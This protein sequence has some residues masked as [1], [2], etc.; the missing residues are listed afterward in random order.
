MKY[1]NRLIQQ[2]KSNY[3]LD[4]LHF[5]QGHKHIIDP[6]DPRRTVSI[7]IIVASFKRISKKVY[8]N[9][10]D[11]VVGPRLTHAELEWVLK[12]FANPT[13][14]PP[15]NWKKSPQFGSMGAKTI[16]FEPTNTE[17]EDLLSLKITYLITYLAGI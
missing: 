7:S 15:W 2:V 9:R 3:G 1:K 12:K 16:L 11:I 6:A 8:K 10:K 5:F 14:Y 13:S 4:D 17:V